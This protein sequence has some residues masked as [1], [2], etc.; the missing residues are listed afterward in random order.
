M[1]PPELG[2][3]VLITVDPESISPDVLQRIEYLAAIGPDA[4]RAVASFCE[5]VG[6]PAPGSVGKSPER[7]QALLWRIHS[8]ELTIV[9]PIQPRPERQRHIR[10]YAEGELGEDNSFYFRGP[11]GALNLR[12]QNLALFLQIAAGVDDRT[13]EHHLRAGDYSRWFREK[14]KD[15]EL[16]S[17]V[18]GIER[19]EALFPADSRRLVK[20]AIDLRYT[21]SA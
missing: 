10:K 18:S 11:E 8:G 20:E 3:T 2:G 6:K 19:D 1:L 14:I 12:A 17:E 7:G 9:S 21:G 5:M 4:D 16:A 15:L 13:R